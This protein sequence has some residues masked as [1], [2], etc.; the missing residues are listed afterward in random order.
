[1]NKALQRQEDNIDHYIA[2]V[3][4]HPLL[5]REQEVELAR[6]Y[7][8][9]GDITAA[10]QLVVANLRFVVKVAHEYKGYGLRLLDIIQEGNIGLMMAVKKFDPDKGYRLISYAVWWIRA[11]IRDFVMRSWS[12]VKLNS[13]HAARKLFFRL[14]SS[15]S[16]AEQ[17]QKT[18]VVSAAS[19]AKDLG[20]E[21]SDVLDM[22]MRLASRD[23][24]LNQKINDDGPQTHMDFLADAAQSPEEQL[25]VHEERRLLK[26]KVAESLEGLTD[27]ERYI[28]DQHL[29]ADEPKTLQ[30]IGDEFKVSRERVRQIES[31]ALAKLRRALEPNAA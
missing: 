6:R 21:E 3:N 9:D 24:S 2:E 30:E 14:R 29:L 7:R 25:E 11:Y 10:H 19:L 12:L 18:D 15:R 28:V 5:S 1:M 23:F 17:N 8:D 4:K 20:V 22:E 16:Q 27:K 13:S 31:K 26:G